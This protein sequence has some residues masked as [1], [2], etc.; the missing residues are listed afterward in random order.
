M[1]N[2][3]NFQSSIESLVREGYLI[4][5]IMYGSTYHYFYVYQFQ[6]AEENAVSYHTA[7]GI[8]ITNFLEVNHGNVD[9]AQFLSRFIQRI[10]KAEMI[11]VE[12]SKNATWYKWAS[13]SEKK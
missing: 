2:N 8:N 13:F 4:L 1:E 3:Y 12:F 7:V 5:Q 10:E 9:R 6:T 11:R